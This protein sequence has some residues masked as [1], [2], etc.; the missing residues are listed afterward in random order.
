MITVS[1]LAFFIGIAKSHFFFGFIPYGN[2]IEGGLG[3]DGIPPI[4]GGGGPIP[5]GGGGGGGPPNVKAS[6]DT[7][8]PTIF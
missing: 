7:N 4:G 1:Q 2:W 6:L 3:A 5:G 8:T